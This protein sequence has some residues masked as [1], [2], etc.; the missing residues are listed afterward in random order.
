M[1]RSEFVERHSRVHPAAPAMIF[2]PVIAACSW[3]AVSARQ[4][5]WTIALCFAFG[6]LVWSLIEYVTHR[7]VFHPD[8]RIEDETRR[9]VAA[10]LPGEAAMPALPTFR[11][12]RYF[13]VHGVHHD[14]PRDS[15]R[16]LVPPVVSIP[17][18]AVAALLT[19]W[20]FGSLAPAMFAGG[21]A[22]YLVYDE[23]H[24]FT[25]HGGMLTAYGRYL[26]K[27][28]LRHHYADPTKDFGV[29]SPLWDFVLGTSG[30]ERAHR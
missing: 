3:L 28:H 11:H 5:A 15:G 27:R 18:A 23:V 24:Y 22:G 21:A 16:L 1:F 13:M 8:P 12:K 4:S 10:L 25:H 6:A 26:A 7:F 20:V 30:R 14:Y 17:Y 19:H 9:I 29:S 2:L